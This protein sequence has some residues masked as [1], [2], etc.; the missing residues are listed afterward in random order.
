MRQNVIISIDI[1]T[2]NLGVCVMAERL[3][4]SGN[5][6]NAILVD[7]NDDPLL[8]VT[9]FIKKW[10]LINLV[11]NTSTAN[12]SVD[13]SPVRAS[14]STVDK[15]PRQLCGSAALTERLQTICGDP[16]SKKR[17]R[18]PIDCKRPAAF[19][20]PIQLHNAPAALCA[21][22]AKQVHEDATI[23]F[24]FCNSDWVGSNYKKMKVGDMRG[25]LARAYK[26]SEEHCR[27]VASLSKTVLVERMAEFTAA[28]CM[29]PLNPTR[30]KTHLRAGSVNG[31]T[32]HLTVVV[33]RIIEQFTAAFVHSGEFSDQD[34]NVTSVLI[35]NQIGPKANRMMAI[36]SAVSMYFMMQFPQAV[37]HSLSSRH[38]LAVASL[39]APPVHANTTHGDRKQTSEI[40]TQLILSKY[41]HIGGRAYTE[42]WFAS[43]LH[44]KKDDIADAFL[45]CVWFILNNLHK[46]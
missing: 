27:Q 4:N 28:H 43:K 17:T 22:H 2:V 25:A 20:L 41:P 26:S 12:L 32:V 46:N 37:V 40:S 16:A 33:R 34:V 6:G 24:L 14:K 7:A 38:K 19:S 31:R 13:T 18:S 44:P 5:S 42:S 8:N 15:P 1:G 36:Q 35:E 11:D 29:Q 45:Q 3:G 21:K 39:V 9:H 10:F 23:P 30:S